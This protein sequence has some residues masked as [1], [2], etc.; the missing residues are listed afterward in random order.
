MKQEKKMKWKN[1]STR[2]TGNFAAKLHFNP[3]T[4]SGPSDAEDTHHLINHH[5]FDYD[6][7]S[8]DKT[9]I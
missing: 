1:N 4:E 3:K 6:M 8:F 5:N 2:K 7:A 9:T